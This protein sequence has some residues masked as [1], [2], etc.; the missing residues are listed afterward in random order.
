MATALLA[1]VTAGLIAAPAV[2]VPEVATTGIFA[3][4]LEPET[5]ADIDRSQVELGVRFRPGTS[6]SVTA[7]Q[8][9]QGERSGAVTT[10]TLWGSDGSVLARV[11]FEE[12]AEVGWRTIGLETPVELTAGSQYTVSYNAPR[13][14]YP[15]IEEDLDSARQQNG[16]ALRA[17]AGVFRYGD[18]SEVPTDTHEGSNYLVDI[19]YLPTDGG[20]EQPPAPTPTASPTPRPT[21][22]PSPTPTP[23]RT[24]TPTPTPTAEPMPTPTAEPTPP[25]GGIVVL[26]RSFPSAETTGVPAGTALTRYTGPCEIQTAGFVIDAKQVDCDLRI[27]ARDVEIRNSAINGSVYAD[28]N[29]NAASFTITDSEVNAGNGPGT[30][31]GDAYFTATRVEVTGGTRSINCYGNCT[32]QDS[33]VHGQFHDTSGVHHESGI[34]IN[35]NSNLIHNTIA[36]DAPDFAPDAGCSAAITGYPDFDPVQN[37]TVDGNLIRAGSGGYCAY[38]GSTAGKPFS[39]QTRDIRFT[40]NVWERGT[41]TGAGGRGYVCG[42]WGAITSFDINAPGN[43]WSNNLFDDGTRV[44]PAN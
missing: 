23:T 11:S 33:Y 9:Y 29:A 36:C 39:G 15:V 16:F 24:P 14:R 22:T 19:V 21:A 3:D 40:N 37:N 7:L 20:A 12:S 30:G 6:G 32:V 18:T 34:R 4:D 13:G 26:G 28:Y 25:S 42:W 31:I 10:A 38:G 17:G 35:T 1:L 5:T 8:Y 44:A 43:V 2:A 41:Q 27:L